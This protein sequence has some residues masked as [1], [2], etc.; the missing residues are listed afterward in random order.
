M[1]FLLSLF[2]LPSHEELQVWLNITLV[3]GLKILGALIVFMFG[4]WL[5]GIIDDRLR[6]HMSLIP[7]MDSTLVPLLA[8]V[9]R[10]S[11]VF[12]TFMAVLPILGIPVASFLVLLSGAALAIGLALQGT[13]A[14]VAS[15]FVLL[16]LR[17]FNLGDF[18]A[19]SDQKGKIVEIGL[20]VT[21]LTTLE[22]RVVTVPN[23]AVLASTIINYSRNPS[24]RTNWG[25]DVAYDTDLP[26]AVALIREILGEDE[27]I[28]NEPAPEVFVDGFGASAV[29]IQIRA[30]AP[31]SDFW[32]M[33]RDLRIR[34]KQRFDK[35]GI[36]IPFPQ[37]VLHM[38]SEN[39]N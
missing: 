36:T 30:A 17:P 4:W 22:Y 9:I 2:S 32:Q 20:F 5:S 16:I 26:S 3:F 7:R 34:I 10:Y 6:K 1:E 27:R 38:V 21:T 8:T 13:L 14:N 39:K 12:S 29:T 24:L 35:E 25:I 11:L 18:V 33:E 15:G 23:T 28:L 19:V 37:R 31:T